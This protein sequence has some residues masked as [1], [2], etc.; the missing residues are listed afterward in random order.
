[1]LLKIAGDKGVKGQ[2]H[3][4]KELGQFEQENKKVLDYSLKCVVNV[5]ESMLI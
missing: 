1:M 2:S 3:Q 4:V 5:C